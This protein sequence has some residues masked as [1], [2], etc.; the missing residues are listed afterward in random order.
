LSLSSRSAL[1]LYD[2]A[3]ESAHLCGRHRRAQAKIVS[4]CVGVK[5]EE[6]KWK[7]R[8]LLNFPFWNFFFLNP[9][10]FQALNLVCKLVRCF[11]LLMSRTAAAAAAAEV[12]EKKGSRSS[13]WS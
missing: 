8:V 10:F 6:G 5:R 3:C 9:I 4:I 13:F 1:A 12:K 11:V 7:E 2:R